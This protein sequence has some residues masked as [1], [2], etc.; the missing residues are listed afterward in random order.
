[1]D[2]REGIA[3]ED[4][5]ILDSLPVELP[6]ICIY[7]KIDLLEK[8]PQ[9]PGQ[10]EGGSKREVWVSAK[11]GA[12]IELLRRALLEMAGW[13][14]HMDEGVFLARRRHLLALTEAGEYL[15]CASG[16]IEHGDYGDRLELLAEELRLAQQSLSSI[17]GEFTADVSRVAP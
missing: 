13:N 3:P 15:R 1:M 2:S 7:N 17:T 6:R 9:I 8:L 10:C 11:T 4:Q 14:P 12:G 5:A 16:V